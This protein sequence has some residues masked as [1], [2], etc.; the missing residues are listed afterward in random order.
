VW[1]AQILASAISGAAS[2][3][4]QVAR[5]VAG[6]VLMG[7][8]SLI[9]AARMAAAWF[10][11][12]GPIGW[13]IAAVVGIVTLI[14]LNWK[15]VVSW[16]TTA[17]HAV[18]G[19]IQAVWGAIKTG[20][21]AALR[22]LLNLFLNFTGPG[23]IIK[24]W[25]AIKNFTVTAWNA[26][27]GFIR[28]A[29]GRITGAISDGV[30]AAVRFVT[31]LGGRIV[32]GLA[33]FG[34]LLYQKGRD[35]IQGLIN[36]AGSLLRNI[37]SFFLN[38]VPGWIR[39]PLEHALGISSPSTVFAEY[40]RNLGQGLINGVTGMRGQIGST[41]GGLV[42][43]PT[44]GLGYR[45]PAYAGGM[46]GVAARGAATYVTQVSG[47]A[48]PEQVAAQVVRAQRTNEFLAGAGR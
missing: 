21:S 29:W 10:I 47:V 30:G 12:L 23:L 42:D 27:V 22:F 5:V 7:L 25:T 43:T 6:W 17:W 34:S 19:A 28:G 24:H 13:V 37:G 39:S 8:Q 38:I 16:T 41:L 20:I 2:F 45:A 1:T 3:A 35:L 32:R 26:V 9:Q 46:A 4:V 36:G 44:G 33:G 18:W 48:S 11:A 14:I 15:K 40:G 31:G